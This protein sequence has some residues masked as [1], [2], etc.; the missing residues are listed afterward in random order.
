LHDQYAWLDAQQVA[1]GPEDHPLVSYSVALNASEHDWSFK[2]ARGFADV[3]NHY[4]VDG[5]DPTVNSPSFGDT[6]TIK[7][8]GTVKI[9]PFRHS[10]AYDQ[11]KRFTLVNHLALGKPITFSNPVAPQYGAGDVLV[12]GI[13]GNREFFDGRWAAWH[14]NDFRATIDLQQPT[15]IHAIDVDFLL[16]PESRILLPQ[17]VYFFV[18]MDGQNWTPVYT[19]APEPD[20]SS[21]MR[22]QHVG[23]AS[24][25]PIA[26]RYVRVNAERYLSLPASFSGD[27]KDT[28]LFVDE[29]Q[30]H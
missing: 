25:Q 10:V 5:T 29:I 2:A 15:T 3:Q 19:Y 16:R 30:I 20:F 4:T 14:N 22:I 26:A 21:P 9:A 1:Y 11:A 6:L 8:P 7:T 24:S 27:T 23:F 18:S 17:K 13:L 28:W 12:D